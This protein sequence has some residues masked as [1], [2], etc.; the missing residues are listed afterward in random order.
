MN[1]IIRSALV[2]AF[3]AIIAMVGRH[4]Y[5]S[6]L[7][8]GVIQSSGQIDKKLKE[9]TN[10]IVA[11]VFELI[12]SGEVE[13]LSTYAYAYGSQ[14]ALDEMKEAAESVRTSLCDYEYELVDE[15]YVASKKL[16]IKSY[17]EADFEYDDRY[18]IGFHEDGRNIIKVFRFG[19][20]DERNLLSVKLQYR[21]GWKLSGIESESLLLKGMTEAEWEAN[22]DTLLNENHK[23]AAIACYWNASE[24]HLG[25][26]IA[27]KFRERASE[28]H[29]KLVNEDKDITLPFAIEGIESAPEIFNIRVFKSDA[30]DEQCYKIYYKTS[31]EVSNG[32]DSASSEQL[33]RDEAKRIHSHLVDQ[34][35]I[36][37]QSKHIYL[38]FD[39]PGIM[40]ISDEVERSAVLIEF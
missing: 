30:E 2:I 29:T 8:T 36:E 17:Y 27:Y 21:G 9:K 39:E 25:R 13:E 37:E 4:I 35:L 33:I 31:I 7:E 38:A 6:D 22:G 20:P 23:L 40:A 14:E 32:K 5:I 24:F 1:I 19:N 12:K 16:H 34:G 3:V 26:N 18:Y 15:F 28:K 11:E 10:V